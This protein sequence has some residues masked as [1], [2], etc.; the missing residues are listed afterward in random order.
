M[1]SPPYPMTHDAMET[2]EEILEN[3]P[4]FRLVLLAYTLECLLSGEFEDG[5]PMLHL[6]IKTAIGIQEFGKL[7]N[8]SPDDLDDMLSHDGDLHA[9]NLS[10]IVGCIQEHQKIRLKVRAIQE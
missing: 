10:K 5:K 7:I 4:K 6:Y 1:E 3:D 2:M 8:F 9:D